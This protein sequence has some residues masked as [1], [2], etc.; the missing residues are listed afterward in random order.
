MNGTVAPYYITNSKHHGTYYSITASLQKGFDFGLNLMAAYTR[1]DSKSIQEGYGDQVSSL[2][3]GGNYSVNGSNIPELGHSAFVTPNRVIANISYR[4]AEG[5]HLATTIGLFY[6]GYNH[7]YVG[8]YSYTRYS[9]TFGVRSGNYVND[10][11]GVG[12]SQNLMYIPTDEDLAKM[13]FKDE[14]NKADFKA[15]IEN[16]RYLSRH[17]GH[18]SERGAKISPWQNRINLKV[19]EDFTLNIAEKPTTLQIGLDINNVA[20]LLNS[21]WGLT[22]Q[23]SSENIL[24]ISK[25]DPSGVYTFNAPTIQ[26]YRSYFNTWQMLLSVRLYF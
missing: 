11:T 1:A 19:A 22:E 21:N 8:G 23:V 4:I 17:R 7:C 5:D 3:S 14:G 10:V 26:K 13:T 20:N 25:A 15:F 18:Y 2:F 24:E 16:D 6:E 12:G 9:Y